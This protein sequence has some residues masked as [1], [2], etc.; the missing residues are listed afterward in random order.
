MALKNVVVAYL[1][2]YLPFLTHQEV[3]DAKEGLHALQHKNYASNVVELLDTRR[4]STLRE[5]NASWSHV[6]PSWTRL[7]R[8]LT[9]SI[10]TPQELEDMQVDNQS[11]DQ[12]IST[13]LSCI[14]GRFESPLF[15]STATDRVQLARQLSS[16]V[17]LL[18]H[19]SSTTCQGPCPI[20]TTA[21]LPAFS[22]VIARFFEGT[23]VEMTPLVRLEGF[24][25][26]DNITRH[27]DV[28]WTEEEELYLKQLL[29][30]GFVDQSRSVRLASGWV[31]TCAVP[32][33][34]LD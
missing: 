22:T 21:L 33:Y 7:V 28:D 31:I 11:H 8:E 34:I 1:E 3:E 14:R 30:R 6:D 16:L 23:E 13:T 24:R 9:A 26:I 32:V 17:I 27:G 19:G 12:V 25:L 20:L 15:V 2:S 4:N 18:A 5:Q 10:V 29:E